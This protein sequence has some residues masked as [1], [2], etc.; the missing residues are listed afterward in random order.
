VNFGATHSYRHELRNTFD[1]LVYP[2]LEP[3][4]TVDRTTNS[5]TQPP[6]DPLH[7]FMW[8]QTAGRHYPDYYSRLRSARACSCVGGQLMPSRPEDWS[9]FSGGGKRV[10]LRKFSRWTVD[11][12]AG[13]V[14]RWN[15]WE[16]WRF[17]ESMAAGCLSLM[18]DFE[19]YGAQLPVQPD[20]WVHYIGLDCD[21]LQRDIDRLRADPTG[22]AKIAQSGKEWAVLN[23]S[24]DATARRFIGYL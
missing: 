14:P 24:P 9:V 21:H 3:F 7:R 19:K 15:Q 13:G 16:S 5:R 8:E 20:N 12:V 18:L 22:L 10:L 6:A 1:Q 11:K 4:L 2:K 23:Y 17:W